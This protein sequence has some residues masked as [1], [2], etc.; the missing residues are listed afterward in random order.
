MTF[1]IMYK[2]IIL[3]VFTFA[4]AN[5]LSN[6]T[7]GEI[8][9]AESLADDYLIIPENRPK[10]VR[11]AFH[12]CVGPDGCNGCLNTE[13]SENKGL[14]QIF[15]D[16]N[17]LYQIFSEKLQATQIMSR[18]DFW[19]LFALRVLRYIYPRD[20]TFKT[21][22]YT[23]GRKDCK[24]SP[25]EVEEHN[26]PNPRKGWSHIYEHFGPSS[27]FNLTINETVALIGGAHS[28]GKMHPENSGF[29]RAWDSTEKTCDNY[30]VN[31]LWYGDYEQLK[32]EYGNYQ[33]YIIS[34]SGKYGKN[35]A[36]NTD[37][38]LW[39]NLDIENEEEG[40]LKNCQKDGRTFAH[41]CPDNLDTIGYFEKIA[42]DSTKGLI[43]WE[44]FQVSYWKMLQAGISPTPTPSGSFRVF[45]GLLITVS[46]ILK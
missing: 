41:S 39:K 40:T 30:F 33:W 4:C 17:D 9:L 38:S 37:I 34:S 22:N 14:E 16:L 12:T 7:P 3:L 24:T 10:M 20:G 26:Y 13:Y 44:D 15:E 29:E 46:L 2:L 11:F 42:T 18:A 27:N 5:S 32:N 25:H 6:P 21:E 19:A 23:F 43:L 35:S 8:A 45:Y 28:L 1:T 36:F 31:F